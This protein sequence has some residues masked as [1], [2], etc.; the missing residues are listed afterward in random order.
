MLNLYMKND[1]LSILFPVSFGKIQQTEC[2]SNK[3]NTFT[4]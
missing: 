1:G 2:I 3:N 4:L